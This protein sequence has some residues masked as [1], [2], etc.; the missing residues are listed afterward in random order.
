MD[1]P[2]LSSPLP[3]DASSRSSRIAI[4]ELLH[5]LIVR[6]WAF[7]FAMQLI[8]REVDTHS[9]IGYVLHVPLR[10]VQARKKEAKIPSGLTSQSASARSTSSSFRSL[11]F[12]LSDD[13]HE[14]SN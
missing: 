11:G 10:L 6:F 2:L 9:D 14:E 13:S 4:F 5:A 3:I 7:R 12:S 8:P 1:L